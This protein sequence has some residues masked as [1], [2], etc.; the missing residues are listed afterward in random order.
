M[1]V[2]VE[3][4]DTDPI[5]NVITCLNYKMD[6]VV[7]FGYPQIIEQYRKVTEDFLRKRCGVSEVCFY[8]V[9]EL[10]LGDIEETIEAAIRL[11]RDAGNEIFV[12]ITGGES[13]V[14]V[15][16]GVFAASME[17]P[18]HAYDI[19]AN[20]FLA[21]DRHASYNIETSCQAQDVPFDLDAF[22]ALYGGQINYRLHK[23]LKSVETEEQANLIHAMWDVMMR[24]AEEWNRFSNYLKNSEHPEFL[25]I[26][27]KLSL[28]PPK[29]ARENGIDLFSFYE[30]LDDCEQAG[31]LYDVHH[32]SDSY[33]YAYRNSMVRDSFWDAGS[34]LELHT[35]LI[36]RTFGDDCRIGVHL[37]WDG[38][39]HSQPDEDTTN[40]IDVLLL[41]GYTPVFISCKN[42]HVKK[43]ALYELETV[44]N[45]FG[46]KYAKKVLVATKDLT[47]SDYLRAKEMGIIVISSSRDPKL[48]KLGRKLIRK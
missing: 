7:Y 17:I 39:I 23:G 29:F 43:D 21:L 25:S 35:Y 48:E 11:E 32:D 2:N 47:Q 42:G 44:A 14:L 1:K 45:R 41:Y 13:L 34:I 22:I 27:Q 33:G 24:H 20:R 12:D 8:P 5:E 40:E 30:I 15:A 16:F 10:D 3:F 46:G 4:L 19:A 26:E 37:D 28:K 31:L 18:M 36:A 6:K 38:I 9:T